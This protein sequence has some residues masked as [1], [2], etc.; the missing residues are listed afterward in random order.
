MKQIILLFLWPFIA[1]AQ[2]PVKYV[3]PLIGTAVATVGS[4]AKH[5]GGTENNAMVQPSVTMPFGMTNWT[6]QTTN[7]EKKCVSSYYYKDPLI[8]GFRGSHWLSGSCVQE[9]GSMAIMPV[10]GQLIC[11]PAKRGSGFSHEK[12]FSGP[13]YYKVELDRYNVTA[14]MTATTRCGM[15]CF[16]F[17]TPGDAHLVLNPNSDEGEGFIQLIPKKNELVGYNPVHRIY[18][19]LG[20]RAG[21]SGYFV[22]RFEKPMESFGVYTEDQLLSGKTQLENQ[23]NLGAYVSFKVKKGEPI[24]VKIGTSFVSIEQARKNL[25]VEIPNYDFKNIQQKLYN[26]WDEM[27][28]RIEI[29]SKNTSELTKFYTA[30]YHSFQQPRIYNDVDG[31]YPRFDGNDQTDTICSGNYY[32][33][34]S[35]WDTYRALH[36]LYNLIAPE[37]NADMMRS[38]LKM[39]KVRNWLPIFPMWNSY[40]SAMIGDHV[41]SLIAEAYIKGVIDLTEEDYRL[42]KR[43]A[44]DVPA[45]F[46]EYVDGKGRR[47]LSSYLKF[48]YIPLE[49]PVKEAFH[50]QEQVSRTL[51]YSYDDFSLAQITR[52]M[53][54]TDDYAYFAKRA[55]NYRNIYDP[56]VNN[57]NGRLEN[58]MFAKDFDKNRKMPFITEGT[59]WQ[60]H[61]YVPHD[62]DGLMDLMGG[63]EKFNQTLDQFFA[64]GQYW[65]GNE[66]GHQIPFLYT[67]SGQPW[68]SSKI[69]R[70][71]LNSEYGTDPGG[72]SGNDDSGQMSAWYVFGAMGFYP[73]CPSKPEYA[74]TGPVFEKVTIRLGNGKKLILSAPG[75][76]EKKCYIQSIRL[77]GKNIENYRFSHFD[78]LQGGKIE[79]QMTQVNPK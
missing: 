76:S 51:E 73:V 53:G 54:K 62:V 2:S 12:E 57:M 11:N 13:H 65:H 28:S 47:A 48:G 71:I 78:L 33:D 50:K 20:K 15:F 35:V 43:N 4:G 18:Q 69:V 49:D 6:P 19:G 70:D 52:K 66:P 72:L 22:A 63:K 17:H 8:A 77:N 36:G 37:Q 3:N 29:E 21:F 42:L 68:K 59:P 34:F 23:P 25:D 46:D 31:Q 41:I 44:M 64:E 5:G 67:Y 58:G 60:Y 79:Y 27:L 55:Q 75:V 24:R 45:S 56:E 38:L 39:G 30:M 74:V 9:Y 7:T 26:T 61:W 40:T 10:S 32:C 14:E 1:V 16:T